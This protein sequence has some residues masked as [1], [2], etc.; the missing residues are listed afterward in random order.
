MSSPHHRPF[1]SESDRAPNI[2]AEIML[3]LFLV[4]GFCGVVWLLFKL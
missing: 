3:A 4:A 1:G 2:G